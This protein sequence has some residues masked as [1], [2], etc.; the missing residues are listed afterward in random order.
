VRVRAAGLFSFLPVV[1]KQVI[2]M[3]S[4]ILPASVLSSER[5]VS[6]YSARVS[7]YQTINIGDNQNMGHRDVDAMHIHSGNV[8]A[9]FLP[10]Q[11]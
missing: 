8:E 10:F 5:S 9:S 4:R 1:E 7:G 3:A 2:E 11:S 6:G